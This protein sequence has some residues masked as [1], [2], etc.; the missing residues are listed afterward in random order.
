MKNGLIVAA[1][2]LAGCG[3]DIDLG[4]SQNI[5]AG[6]P[7]PPPMTSQGSATSGC[8]LEDPALLKAPD[9]CPDQDPP[10]SLLSPV[11]AC[12]VTAGGPVRRPED[13]LPVVP[14]C[15]TGAYFTLKD[16]F[17]P[18]NIE[19]AVSAFKGESDFIPAFFPGQGMRIPRT[20]EVF[21][22]RTSF[23][24]RIDPRPGNGRRVDVFLNDSE[25]YRGT[26]G[27]VSYGVVFLAGTPD[28]P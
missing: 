4:S 8:P 28:I 13:H 21:P 6:A 26:P 7:Q 1:A 11:V 24:V 5:T 20:I 16:P 22:D 27:P 3:Q 12:V 15:P 18:E 19:R 17:P 9:A 14:A 2:L 10:P 25:L 23:F